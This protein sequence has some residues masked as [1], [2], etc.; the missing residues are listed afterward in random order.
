MKE[1][2]LAEN[3]VPMS[4]VAPLRAALGALLGSCPATPEA[5]EHARKA[6]ETYDSRPALRTWTVLYE[7]RHGSDVFVVLSEEVPDGEEL[8]A[9][10]YEPD[11]DDEYITVGHATV[12]ALEPGETERARLMESLAP[13]PE[14]GRER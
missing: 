13:Q 1:R 2:E 12:L 14:A 9:E 5:L 10:V 8:L 11:R 3:L 7:H 6:L 4:E